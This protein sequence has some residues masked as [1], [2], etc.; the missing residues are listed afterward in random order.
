MRRAYA[1]RMKTHPGAQGAPQTFQPW[2]MEQ[3]TAALSTAVAQAA[4]KGGQV[5]YQHG[6]HAVVVI[7]KRP[8]KGHL[9]CTI[10]TFGLWAPIWLTAAALARD[11][12][13]AYYVD[14]YGRV[15]VTKK[16]GRA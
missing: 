4:R 14:E 13:H 16:T 8:R 6:P 10:F 1:Q 3:R 5:E 12:R 11:V 2:T 7:K 9:M 15:S